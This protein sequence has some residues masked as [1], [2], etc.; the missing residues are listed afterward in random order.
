[1]PPL[2]SEMVEYYE[3]RALFDYNPATPDEL[4]LRAG[5]PVEVRVDRGGEN[6]GEEGWLSG[7]DLLGNHGTFPA[8]YVIDRRI[9]SSNKNDDGDDDDRHAAG[10]VVT[11]SNG[12]PPVVGQQREIVP[13]GGGP[14]G[15]QYERGGDDAAQPP[16]EKVLPAHGSYNVASSARRAEDATSPHAGR[17]GGGS[18]ATATPQRDPWPHDDSPHPLQEGWFSGTE[19]ATGEEFYYNA[20]GR[21]S[22][23]R[24]TA[25]PLSAESKRIGVQTMSEGSSFGGGVADNS[26][27]VS[28]TR[29]TVY[30]TVLLCAAMALPMT[31]SRMSGK[32]TQAL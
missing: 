32:Y 25:V 20:D 11:L 9:N 23:V 24:P 21:T 12:E 19:E 22:W 10:G 6:V 31:P 26:N 1:M 29:T 3:A 16:M 15:Q 27:Y 30:K 18:I 7:S 8:S 5:E 28:D 14:R 2:L 17:P 13:I 4:R